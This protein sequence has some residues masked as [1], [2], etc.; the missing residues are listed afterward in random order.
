[1]YKV[2]SEHLSN[3]SVFSSFLLAAPFFESLSETQSERWLNLLLF[4]WEILLLPRF[5]VMFIYKIN[6]QHY[7]VMLDLLLQCNVS[8]WECNSNYFFQSLRLPAFVKPSFGPHKPNDNICNSIFINSTLFVASIQF[9]SI[10]WKFVIMIL[11]SRWFK[12]DIST[13]LSHIHVDSIHVDKAI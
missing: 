2:H 8:Y 11:F 13:Y 6:D 7:K 4:S 12:H 9:L 10:W 5:H 3:L 1:M